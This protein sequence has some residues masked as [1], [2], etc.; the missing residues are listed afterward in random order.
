MCDHCCNE[1]KECFYY[2]ITIACKDIHS[3]IQQANAAEEKLTLNKLLDGWFQTGPK[4]LRISSLTK[5]K[6]SKTQAEF[7]I[8][9]L[10]LK[11]YLSI[12]KGYNTYSTICYIQEGKELHID[13]KIEI[14]SVSRF[15]GFNKRYLDHT[16]NCESSPKKVKIK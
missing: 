1:N 6:I 13:D 3:I 4:K 14:L 12:D 2:D 15:F 8:S 10:L 5:P 7:L 16:S 11:K 9:C